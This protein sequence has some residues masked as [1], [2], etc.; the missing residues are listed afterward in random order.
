[1]HEL[2]LLFLEMN[3]TQCVSNNTKNGENKIV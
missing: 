2:E 3:T 1:M